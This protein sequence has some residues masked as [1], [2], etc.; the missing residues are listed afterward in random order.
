MDK[1]KQY[2]WVL[3]G[4]AAF[5]L[6]FA[7]IYISVQY[8]EAINMLVVVLGFSIFVFGLM[9]IKPIFKAIDDKPY[10]VM[11][12]IE[13]VLGIVVGLIFIF[14]SDFAIEH[15]NKFIGSLLIL[16]GFIYFWAVSRRA[17]FADYY[18]FFAHFI[19]VAVA[20]PIFFFQKNIAR[21]LMWI[22]LL[23]LYV[24]SIIYGYLTYKGY[25]NFR[26]N[27]STRLKLQKHKEVKES[28]VIVDK[29]TEEVP[30]EAPTVNDNEVEK[31]VIV[32]ESEVVD[33]DIIT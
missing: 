15:F 8:T 11:L 2:E 4:I 12:Y 20:I 28:E 26:L 18:S 6:L 25:N 22:I 17:E 23:V 21:E 27:K 31:P 30:K 32:D 5:L 33:Q 9:R 13:L 10:K 29:P 24:M 1:V 7:A 16:R 19:F 14:K 3:K